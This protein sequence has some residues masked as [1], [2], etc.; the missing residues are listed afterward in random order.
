M[1]SRQKVVS[2]FWWWASERQLK[3]FY[4]GENALSTSVSAADYRMP[5]R[6]A[7][8]QDLSVLAFS[9]LKQSL[10]IFIL[11]VVSLWASERK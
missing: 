11:E 9:L 2:K 5:R 10:N 8:Q 6:E 4:S 7:D 1:Y 3:C